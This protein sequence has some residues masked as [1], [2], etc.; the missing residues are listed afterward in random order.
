[1]N[2]AEFRKWYLALLR[3]MKKHDVDLSVAP[4]KVQ[5][6]ALYLHQHALSLAIDKHEP[7]CGCETCEFSR[8]LW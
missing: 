4:K 6:S 1:M 3:D 5:E 7:L 8:R 2:A